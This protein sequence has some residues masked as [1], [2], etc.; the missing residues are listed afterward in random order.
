MNA[1]CGLQSTLSS[2]QQFTDNWSQSAIRKRERKTET[3]YSVIAVGERGK[4]SGALV[5]T[6]HGIFG[7][8]CAKW[9]VACV[10]AA[11]LPLC[12]MFLSTS[13]T[14]SDRKLRSTK[15]PDACPY[16]V[17]VV[18]KHFLHICAQIQDKRS[19]LNIA[20]AFYFCMAF[21]RSKETAAVS[22][23]FDIRRYSLY[24]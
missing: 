24:R 20:S 12:D 21:V 6:I 2:T 7:T 8:F 5:I 22:S 9:S 3:L 23:S 1:S 4:S 15:D 18:P 19:P 13:L 10:R 17:Q 11:T 16:G 14:L